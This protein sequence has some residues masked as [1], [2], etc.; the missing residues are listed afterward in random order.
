M[1]AGQRAVELPWLCPS[2]AA[3]LGLT[4]EPPDPDTLLRDPAAVAHVLRFA[5]PTPDPAEGLLAPSVLA[6]PSLCENA[7]AL[8]EF[9]EP[10]GPGWWDI[11]ELQPILQVSDVAGQLA[12]GLAVSLGYA[13]QWDP[14]KASQYVRQ[15]WP[16]KDELVS[17]GPPRAR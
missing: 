12:S 2:P 16:P 6:Q 1:S 8:L 15:I 4:A 7:A 10:A 17:G 3:L 5:R 9:Q 14:A 13:R 11:R